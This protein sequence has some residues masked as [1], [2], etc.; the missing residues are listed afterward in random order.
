MGKINSRTKGV[1]G[2][3]EFCQWLQNALALEIK[4]QRNL[5]QVRSG[6]HDVLVEPFLFEV[7]RV[8]AVSREKWWLQVCKAAKETEGGLIPVVAFR[9]NRQKWR[10]LISAQYIGLEAGFIELTDKRFKQWM[11]RQM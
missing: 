5:E 1:A 11:V 9:R 2:E 10:F 4:P 3:R 6:G 8:E 7:K